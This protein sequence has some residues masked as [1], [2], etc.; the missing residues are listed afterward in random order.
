MESGVG[1]LHQQFNLIGQGGTVQ[2]KTLRTNPEIKGR[3]GAGQS[4]CQLF[5]G[6]TTDSAFLYHGLGDGGQTDHGFT[7][8]ACA[9]LNREKYL[10]SLKI[11]D[12]GVEAHSARKQGGLYADGFVVNLLSYDTRTLRQWQIGKGFPLRLRPWLNRLGRSGG[13]NSPDRLLG[14]IY[15]QPSTGNTDNFHQSSR[16]IP[17]VTKSSMNVL[18]RHRLENRSIHI[19]FLGRRQDNLVIV[20]LADKRCRQVTAV[21]GS[22]SLRRFIKHGGDLPLAPLQL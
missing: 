13:K 5:P 7:L 10:I 2:G 18:E 1:K 22:S 14:P 8:P 21:A 16:T 17:Q 11:S 20:K 9:K 3:I 19:S 12:L 6:Q 15:C 4:R